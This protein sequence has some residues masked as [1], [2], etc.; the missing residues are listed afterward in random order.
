MD[1]RSAG[2][3]RGGRVARCPHRRG[4]LRCP[5]H[6]PDEGLPGFP[7]ALHPAQAAC[8]AQG[9]VSILRNRVLVLKC[10]S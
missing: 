2:V 8:L 6:G 7:L 1:Q 4:P 5:T 10:V 3:G 9:T